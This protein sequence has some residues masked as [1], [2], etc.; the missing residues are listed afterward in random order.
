MASTIKVNTIAHT[1]GTS[2]M[3]VDSTGRLTRNVIPYIYLRGNTSAEVNTHG[4]VA[5][6]TNWSLEGSA[7][8]GMTWGGSN[9][10]ITVPVDGIYQ[11]AAKFYLWI[12]NV[13]AHSIIIKL[14]DTSFQEYATDFSATGSGGRTDHT[15]TVNEILK[16]T[17]GDFITFSCSADVYGGANH[18]N[19]QMVMLG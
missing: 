16:L 3:T 5:N 12:N 4:T 9:G 15:V 8:G 13:A 2:A 14:N 18:T 17:A 19:C 7:L 11:L 6:Y 10:R 1:G